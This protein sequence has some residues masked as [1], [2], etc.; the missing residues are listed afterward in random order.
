MTDSPIN[1]T[2][3]SIITILVVCIFA[4]L[5][6]GGAIGLA[7]EFGGEDLH[8]QTPL[9]SNGISVVNNECPY[10]NFQTSN[11]TTYSNPTIPFTSITSIEGKNFTQVS[12]ST[13]NAGSGFYCESG[14]KP[15]AY[16]NMGFLFPSS[17]FESGVP[18]T[19]IVLDF[20]ASQTFTYYY[21]L[22]EFDFNMTVNGTTI[23]ELDD[24]RVYGHSGQVN[25]RA[26]FSIDHTLSISEYNDLRKEL[27][28]CSPNC[29]IRFNVNDWQQI[30]SCPTSYCNTLQ[31]PPSYMSL[32]VYESDDISSDL[33]LTIAPWFFGILCALIALGSTPYFNPVWAGA[34]NMKD[35]MKGS[36]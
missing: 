28:E 23:Y 13:P 35:K 5:I 27:E 8:H 19:R 7:V 12:P 16:D 31:A 9:D 34:N 21:R 4:P 14:W 3:Q 6:T 10:S 2:I 30:E 11:P 36:I 29:D 18:Y 33:V 26:E 24:Y 25:N 17:T 32:S 20:K 22:T 15:D 1:G